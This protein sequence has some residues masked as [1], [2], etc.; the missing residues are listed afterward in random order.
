MSTRDRNSDTAAGLG[1]AASSVRAA[2]ET[3][4]QDFTP[5]T[6]AEQ[7]M[8][9]GNRTDLPVGG[10]PAMTDFPIDYA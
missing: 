7:A 5:T 10:A 2:S 8:L 9:G 6:L 1:G 3:W 4:P